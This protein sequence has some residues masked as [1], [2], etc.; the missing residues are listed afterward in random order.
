LEASDHVTIYVNLVIRYGHKA[1]SVFP[2]HQMILVLWW[3]L[4][5]NS[6]AMESCEHERTAKTTQTDSRWETWLL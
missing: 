4:R 2:Y 1:S 3:N 5:F 6:T